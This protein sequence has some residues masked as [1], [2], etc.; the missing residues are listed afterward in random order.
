MQIG[1]SVLPL[2]EVHRLKCVLMACLGTKTDHVKF[3]SP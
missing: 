2:L 1:A 3:D